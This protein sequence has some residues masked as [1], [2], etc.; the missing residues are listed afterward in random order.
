MCYTTLHSTR[1][2]IAQIALCCTLQ[3]PLGEEKEEVR[4]VGGLMFIHPLLLSLFSPSPSPPPLS[5]S[6]P[7]SDIPCISFHVLPHQLLCSALHCVDNSASPVCCNAQNVLDFR[8][9]ELVK[10]TTVYLYLYVVLVFVFQCTIALC[11]IVQ[12]VECILKRVS[13]VG[14]GVRAGKLGRVI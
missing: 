11:P 13:V 2:Y 8:Q 6:L 9:V 12:V 5:P 14:Q 3:P 1:L 4:L 10:C 7:S